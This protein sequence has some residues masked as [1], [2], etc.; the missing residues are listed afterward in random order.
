MSKTSKDSFTAEWTFR[1]KT[2]MGQQVGVLPLYQD[3]KETACV[4]VDQREL[5]AWCKAFPTLFPAENQE[6][7]DFAE[8]LTKQAI[9]TLQA[10]GRARWYRDI[11]TDLA[12]A[13]SSKDKG[14][15]SEDVGK[16]LDESTE[17]E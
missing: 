13:L 10:V 12:L 11:I 7:K 17:S 8:F 15:T 14:A 5:I 6:E 4:H 1:K 3:L 16:L 9:P 2:A